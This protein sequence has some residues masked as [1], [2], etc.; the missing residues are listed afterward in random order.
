MRNRSPLE[1]VVP[2]YTIV[3]GEDEPSTIIAYSLS[4]DDYLENLRAIRENYAENTADEIS[5][6]EESEKTML[7]DMNEPPV[8]SGV[9]IERTLRSKSGSHMK[10]RK[11][12]YYHSRTTV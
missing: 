9:F 8:G 2:G 12:V 7:G 6:S 4:C 1:H 3:V 10:Y 5:L 11:F